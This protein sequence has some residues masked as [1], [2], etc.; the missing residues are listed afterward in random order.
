MGRQKKKA[1]N[2]LTGIQAGFH[3]NKT[4]FKP[5]EAK[6]IKNIHQFPLFEG[7]DETYLLMCTL[8]ILLGKL[9]ADYYIA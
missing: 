6:H 9:T 8:K 5:N 7:I 2:V 3:I 4:L 1:N